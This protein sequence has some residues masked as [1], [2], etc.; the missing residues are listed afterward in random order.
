[1][2]DTMWT[3]PCTSLIPWVCRRQKSNDLQAG[4]R[5][6]Q[7]LMHSLH[8]FLLH[9]KTCSSMNAQQAAAVPCYVFMEA[10]SRYACDKSNV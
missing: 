2:N 4:G 6:R 3:T 10:F 9:G 7:K 1:M 8:S 5:D